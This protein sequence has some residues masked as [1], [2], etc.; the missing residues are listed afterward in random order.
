[1]YRFTLLFFGEKSNIWR[2]K[3]AGKLELPTRSSYLAYL[4]KLLR[5]NFNK[6]SGS[7]NRP[8]QPGLEKLFIFLNL[9]VNS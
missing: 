6:P 5:L 4:P 3:K 8:G 7:E 9:P 2:I 1:M